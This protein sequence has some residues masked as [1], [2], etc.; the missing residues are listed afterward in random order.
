MDSHHSSFS[1]SSTPAPVEVPP[2]PKNAPQLL[3]GMKDILP[4]DQPWFQAVLHAAER[5]AASGGFQRIETPVLEQEGLYNRTVGTET[6]IVSKEMYT[7]VD[8][9]GDKVALRPEATAG[10][11]RSYLEHGL[12][13]WPQPVKFWWVGPLFRYDRPQAGRYRQHWQFD[14]EVIGD[15][16]PVIDA[17]LIV[18][19]TNFYQALGIPVTVQINSLG[20]SQCRPAYV[21]ALTD[22]YKTRKNALCETCK[23]RLTTSPLR[24]LDCKEADCQELAREAPQIVDHLCEPCRQHFVTVL[25]Y[26]DDIEVPYSLA[27]KLVRG[28]D[29]YTRTTFEFLPEGATGSQSALG[30]GGRYDK[31]VEQL[32]G[33]PTPAVGF[34]LGIERIISA[35]RERNLPGLEPRRPDVFLAQLGLEARKKCMRLFQ[36]FQREGIIVSEAFSKD[37]LKQQ[38]EV[39]NR[40]KAAFTLIIGQ[41]ELMDDTILIRDMENGIQEIVDFQKVVSE[42]KKRLAKLPSTSTTTHFTPSPEPAAPAQPLRGTSMTGPDEPP[43]DME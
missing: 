26:L 36:A 41:K 21:K 4:P 24:L 25:E 9:G 23:K 40:L 1:R 35:M 6:D 38:L 39:A 3:R 15:G 20:D 43:G 33:Q 34:G 30:G 8:R 7:F 29:Y 16:N 28:Q 12:V 13:S 42:V 5:T 32:G 11:V 18:L 19:A 22:Y 27:P 31:L 14:C 2:R 17:Q 10:I 37:G